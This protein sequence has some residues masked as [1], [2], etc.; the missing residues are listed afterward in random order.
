MRYVKAGIFSPLLEAVS[1]GKNLNRKGNKWGTQRA[2]CFY[3]EIFIL[4]GLCEKLLRLCVIKTFEILS[5]KC[6]HCVTW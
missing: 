3:F 6:R 5:I 1:K 2:Q 4:F